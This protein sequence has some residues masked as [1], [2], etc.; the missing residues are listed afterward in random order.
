MAE[1]PLVMKRTGPPE[2]GPGG[3]GG[4][5]RRSVGQFGLGLRLADDDLRSV[6]REIFELHVEAV[7][8]AVR[9]CGPDRLP[10]VALAVLGHGVNAVAR[11]VVGLAHVM[12]LSSWFEAMHLARLRGAPRP[13]RKSGAFKGCRRH[14]ETTR[15]CTSRSEAKA[16]KRAA[17][18][19]ARARA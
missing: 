2:G 11:A 14:R 5:A 15:R 3:L 10:E 8:V 12:F 1:T 9:P 18:N 6:E 16:R 19:A 4:F 17:L 7:A 13:A